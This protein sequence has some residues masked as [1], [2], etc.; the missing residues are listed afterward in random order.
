MM[1]ELGL[2][3]ALSLGAALVC[4]VVLMQALSVE[5]NA[6]AKVASILGLFFLVVS[7]ALWL[8]NMSV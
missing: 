2:V 1:G 7:A 8:L 5:K 4:I 6:R 3:A